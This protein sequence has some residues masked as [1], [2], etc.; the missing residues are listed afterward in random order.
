MIP[1]LHGSGSFYHGPKMTP[2]QRLWPLWE[3]LSSVSHLSPLG[4]VVPSQKTELDLPV[5]SPFQTDKSALQPSSELQPNT[6]RFP[7]L[8]PTGHWCSPHHSILRVGTKEIQLLESEL[9]SSQWEGSWDWALT[10]TCSS[11]RVENKVTLVT[12]LSTSYTSRMTSESP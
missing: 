11:D 3:E 7:A 10:F 9:N 2:L 1:K 6:G 12:L 5:P 4:Q 8:H